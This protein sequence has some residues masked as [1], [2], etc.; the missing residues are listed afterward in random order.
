MFSTFQIKRQNEKRETLSGRCYELY[1]CRSNL[2][3]SSDVAVTLLRSR[4]TLSQNLIVATFYIR[5][6][7]KDQSQHCK[8]VTEMSIVIV[9]NS[10]LQSGS[11][12]ELDKVIR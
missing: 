10:F 12:I 5:S 11:L 4:I 2:R 3:C 7:S 6:R 1:N 9:K 8:S